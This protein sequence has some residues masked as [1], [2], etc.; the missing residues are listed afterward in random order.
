MHPCTLVTK[1]VF[2]YESDIN[3]N[4]AITINATRHDLY[5]CIRNSQLCEHEYTK[6]A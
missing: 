2:Q 5:H 4:V 3:I 6:A 1:F